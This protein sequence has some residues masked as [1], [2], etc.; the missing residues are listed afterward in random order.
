LN[1]KSIISVNLLQAIWPAR[2]PF[3]FCVYHKDDYPS[4]NDSM[5]P[6]ASLKGRNLGNDFDPKNAWRMYH[7]KTVPGFPGH[8]HR[9]FE[10]VTAVLKGFVDHSDS[11]GQSGRYGMGDV[12]WMTAGKGLQHSEMFPLLNKDKDNPLELFQIWLNLP[13]AKKFAE[14]FFKMLWSEEIPLVKI[15][16]ENGVESEVRVVAGEYNNSKAPAPAPDSWAADPANEV[17]IWIIGLQPGCLWRIP[18]SVN[19]VNRSLYFF[20]GES[21]NIENTVIPK[22]QHIE[23]RSDIQTIIK[24]G[25]D[26]SRLLMLQGKPIGEP[27]IQ[28]GPFVMNMEEEIRQAFSDYQTTRFGGWPWPEYENVYPGEKGRFAKHLDGREEIK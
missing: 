18:Q 22:G 7:G 17:Q 14:S 28:Y 26:E 20:Q 8:P 4:G 13:A 23:L 1:N 3:L 24:N 27:V 15:S 19:R 21:V 10:T 12:Q 6:N 11:H 5:G 16:D 2:D 25:K 9:G